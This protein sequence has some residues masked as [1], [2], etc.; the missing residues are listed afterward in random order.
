[1][2]PHGV[3]VFLAVEHI[4]MRW[5]FNRLSGVVSEKIGRDV[6]CGALFL[7]FGR[8]RSALKILFFDGTGLCLYYKRLDAGTFR[9]PPAIESDSATVQIDE[10]VLDALL[11]GIDLDAKVKRISTSKTPK[12][13]RKNIH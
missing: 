8:T 4:D 11:D 13:R 10:N 9:I 7:F 5:G 12:N 3:E 1:M 6:R 2:I